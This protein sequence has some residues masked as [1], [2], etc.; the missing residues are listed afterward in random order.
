[1]SKET[2]SIGN[3]TLRANGLEGRAIQTA[4]Y[5][6]PEHRQPL[7]YPSGDWYLRQ[8]FVPA[9][10]E[11]ET[12]VCHTLIDGLLPYYKEIGLIPETSTILQIEPQTDEVIAH[13]FPVTDP[14]EILKGQV[15]FEDDS[16]PLT[17]VS[18]F[19]GPTITDQ[20]HALGL[21]TIDRSPSIESNNKSRL[22]EAAPRYGFTMLPGMVLSEWEDLEQVVAASWNSDK[23]MWMKFPTG[24]GGDLVYKVNKAGDLH[25]LHQGVASLRDAVEKSFE[26]A[27]FGESFEEFWPEDALAPNG[28]GL[29]IEA[30]AG[31]LGKVLLNGSTQFVTNRTKRIDVVG[32]FS[33]MTTDEGEYL[34]NEPIETTPEI[35]QLLKEQVLR[36]GAYNMQENNYFGI[37]GIDWFLIEDAQ[38]NLQV[39]VTELNARPTANTPP[40]IIAEKLAAP[41]W[42]NTNLY[43][44]RPM[45]SFEDFEKVIGSD[46]VWGNPDTNGM[47]VPQ[48][49]RTMVRRD[50]I[51]PS[52]NFKALI[53]GKDAAHCRELMQS[54]IDR[55]IAF[56]PSK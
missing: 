41:H 22:R 11:G 55:G 15:L 21:Q 25:P 45:S 31:I 18:T 17:M 10:A 13:G 12:V 7:P 3:T 34:G 53:L 50:G 49:F 40:V 56:A 16:N 1:M 32:H 37:Q 33:Q 19:T 44:G 2:L 28:F 27:S 47:V 30:D 24:S 9:I 52:P 6:S 26:Q 38:G 4:N 51:V 35:N 48:A 20:A 42:I 36:V 46:L 8:T 14:M 5:V 29:S 39:T 43:T 54:L 23:G